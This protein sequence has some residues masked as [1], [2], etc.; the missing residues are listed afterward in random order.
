[1]SPDGWLL[2]LTGTGSAL[3][4]GLLAGV[5]LGFRIVSRDAALL[6]VLDKRVG[7]ALTKSSEAAARAALLEAT[8]EEHLAELERKRK[9]AAAER[10]RA[11]A[12]AEPE[13]PEA[14]AAPAPE[15][16]PRE[17]RR[18]LARLANMG[19]GRGAA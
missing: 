6:A 3:A 18:Q 1:L 4:V 11:D 15:L 10:Q 16:T 12:K 2:A 7:D 17:R 9:K 14:A 19:G 13:E 8:W 5:W